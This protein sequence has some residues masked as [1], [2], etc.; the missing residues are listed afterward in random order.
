MQIFGFLITYTF[1]YSVSIIA[2][3]LPAEQVLRI[4]KTGIRNKLLD[5]FD[6]IIY[7]QNG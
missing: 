3:S 5:F 7:N 2:E 1:C 6:P 4:I